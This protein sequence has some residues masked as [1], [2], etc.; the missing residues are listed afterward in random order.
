MGGVYCED[1][2]IAETAG[3]GRE[4]G[5]HTAA[6]D[7]EQAARLWALPARLTGVDAC[8]ATASNRRGPPGVTGAAGDRAAIGSGGGDRPRPD[9]LRP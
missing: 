6:T 2:D 1:C 3:G 7:P 4:G 5:V 8:A 9:R